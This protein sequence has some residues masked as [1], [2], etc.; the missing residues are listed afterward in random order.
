VQGEAAEA[1]FVQLEDEKTKG[2][3]IAVFN[4]LKEGI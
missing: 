4:Y 1:E 2:D 3:L